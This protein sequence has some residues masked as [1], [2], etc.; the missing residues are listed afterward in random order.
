[1]SAKRKYGKIMAV[2][3]SVK[4]GEKKTNAGSAMLM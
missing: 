1:M 4:K 3:I 2:N